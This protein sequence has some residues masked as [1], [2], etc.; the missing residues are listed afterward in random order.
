[1][2]KRSETLASRIPARLSNSGLLSTFLSDFYAEAKRFQGR[3]KTDP[4]LDGTAV[5][6]QYLSRSGSKRESS[7]RIGKYRW[8]ARKILEKS[9]THLM[10]MPK[11]SGLKRSLIADKKATFTKVYCIQ[12]HNSFEDEREAVAKVF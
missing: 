10:I 7:L 11:K 9:P 6:I 1:M 5:S 2:M 8:F 4:K 3:G 12:S